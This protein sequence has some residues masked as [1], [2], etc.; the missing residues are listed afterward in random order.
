[1]T[2]SRRQ[3]LRRARRGSA[4]ACGWGLVS[5][6]G[7]AVAIGAL[8]STGCATRAATAS[9]LTTA[10][11]A[12]VIVGATMA[13]DTHC[14]QSSH[15]AGGAY[16]SPGLSK[17]TRNAGTA[18]AIAGVG[19]AAAGYALQP[20]GPDQL[21]PAPSPRA[22]TRPYRLLRRPVVPATTPSAGSP[23]A[24]VEAGVAADPEL[25]EPAAPEP[26]PALTPTAPHVEDP[27]WQPPPV[28]E[29]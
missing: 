23:A 26:S 16:C 1:M 10:G 21:G 20:R 24:T 15:G 8:A 4:W 22:P 28:P 25:G 12:A 14:Y 7:W 27:D 2:A 9:V 29:Q 13:A 17:G 5:T 3:G 19:A 11:A 6:C 18:L